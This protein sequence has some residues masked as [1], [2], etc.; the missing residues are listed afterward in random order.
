MYK[1][2]SILEPVHINRL[3][4]WKSERS[5]QTSMTQ[6]L[7]KQEHIDRRALSYFEATSLELTDDRIGAL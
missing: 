6:T 5:R 3:T 4:K 7:R 1:Q 2:C